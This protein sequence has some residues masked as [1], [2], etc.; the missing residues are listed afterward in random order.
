M[1][2]TT[3]AWL[4][5][6]NLISSTAI[7]YNT[8]LMHSCHMEVY[9]S[10]VILREKSLAPLCQPALIG[11]TYD[12]P[13]VI[14]LCSG[15]N[16]WPIWKAPPSYLFD[17]KQEGDSELLPKS[18]HDKLSQLVTYHGQSFSSFSTSLS[19]CC[20]SVFSARF[21]CFLH[22]YHSL[23]ISDVNGGREPQHARISATSSP[24]QVPDP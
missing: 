8:A 4:R 22:F 7:L 24:V 15:G 19:Q 16:R 12:D 18:I 3:C 6:A 10:A 5:P 14:I 20:F 23:E 17:Q 9:D 2:S 13:A 21:S 1:A 11:N